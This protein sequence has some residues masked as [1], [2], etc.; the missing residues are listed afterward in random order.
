MFQLLQDII[1][2]YNKNPLL[3]IEFAGHVKSCL[4]GRVVG[5]ITSRKRVGAQ[6]RKHP[7]RDMQKMSKSWNNMFKATSIER[8]I[9]KKNLY[10]DMQINLSSCKTSDYNFSLSRRKMTSFSLPEIIQISPLSW[11]QKKSL[12]DIDCLYVACASERRVRNHP[13]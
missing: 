4:T 7:N 2:S 8:K 9:D 5:Q 3:F 13:T 1:S 11:L 12:V 10:I 6:N